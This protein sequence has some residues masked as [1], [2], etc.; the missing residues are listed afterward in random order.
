MKINIATLGRSISIAIGKAF[1]YTALILPC[2][3][4]FSLDPA[5][6]TN[7]KVTINFPD[8]TANY[9]SSGL[10]IFVQPS[11]RIVAA[12]TFSRFGPDGSMPGLAVVGLTTTGTT[13]A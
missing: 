4:S 6:G 2:L 9:S 8:S 10:R 1:L 3:A 13:D 7:G 5:F 12:G 11:G